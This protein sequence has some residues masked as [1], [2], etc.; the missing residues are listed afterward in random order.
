MD[1]TSIGAI[2][3][4]TEFF[5][6]CV[7]TH[8]LGSRLLL[9]RVAMEKPV[10]SYSLLHV[11]TN[12]HT[13]PSGNEYSTTTDTKSKRRVFGTTIM[14]WKEFPSKTILYLYPRSS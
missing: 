4:Y 14:I 6:K 10:V 1:D 3:K 7:P 9:D 11:K 5:F 12:S 13:D 8:P 2:S